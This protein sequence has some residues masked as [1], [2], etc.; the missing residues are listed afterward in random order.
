MRRKTRLFHYSCDIYAEI[1][2]FLGL[3]RATDPWRSS[4]FEHFTGTYVPLDDHNATRFILQ[5]RD[6]CLIASVDQP[7]F[8]SHRGPIGRFRE[9]RLIP[10]GENRFYVAAW[11]HEIQ[12]IEERIG[13]N[14]KMRAT[15]SEDGSAELSEVYLKQ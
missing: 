12:F 7:T 4:A 10:Q 9:V 3:P 1:V 8:D 11:P 6:G 15:V 14:V 2:D 13:T 5:T